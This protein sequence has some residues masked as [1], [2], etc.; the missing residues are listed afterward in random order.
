[1]G[2]ETPFTSIAELIDFI[3]RIYH[4]PLRHNII[5]IENETKQLLLEYGKKYPELENIHH[6]FI[7]FKSEVLHHIEEEENDFFPV[8]RQ[9]EDCAL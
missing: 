9:I 8:L 3:E 2:N 7:Q 1:M 4:I 6:L 5:W